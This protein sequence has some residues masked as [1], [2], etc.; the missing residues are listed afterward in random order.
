MPEG[1][2]S[3]RTGVRAATP[4]RP[5]DEH[6]IPI[7]EHVLMKFLQILVWGGGVLQTVRAKNVLEGVGRN[8]L[9][10][11]DDDAVAFG[12]FLLGKQAEVKAHGIRE[13][14]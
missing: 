1:A 4:L 7:R 5:E 3:N 13:G 6:E 10:L 14:G 8:V 11:L 12:Q 9:P 2:D